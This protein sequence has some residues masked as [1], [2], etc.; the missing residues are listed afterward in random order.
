MRPLR[1][2]LVGLRTPTPQSPERL[3]STPFD[4]VA[5]AP[6]CFAERKAVLSHALAALTALKVEPGREGNIGCESQKVRRPKRIRSYSLLNIPPV[7]LNKN[8]RIPFFFNKFNS[9]QQRFPFF[10]GEIPVQFLQN[11]I[12]RNILFPPLEKLMV[13]SG[14]IRKPTVVEDLGQRQ[15]QSIFCCIQ[16]FQL[17]FFHVTDKIVSK[18]LSLNKR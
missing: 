9:F 14:K 1:A 8:K 7:F 13:Y 6:C 18:N 4:C 2:L 10:S 15:K 12:R 17:A 11:L 3:R 5:I 16:R